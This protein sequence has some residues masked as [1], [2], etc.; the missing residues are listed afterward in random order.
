[1]LTRQKILLQILRSNDGQ[2]SKMELAKLSF[3]LSKEG[4]SEQLKTF[5]E[6]V[7]YFYGPYSFTLTHELNHLLQAGFIEF[8]DETA[9]KLTTYGAQHAPRDFDARLNR[10]LELLEQKYS[11]LSQN[12]LVDLVYEKF[13]WYT[14]KSKLANKRKSSISLAPCANYTIGYQSFQV[15]GLLNKLLESGIARVVDTRN[16]PISRKY[17]YHKSTLAKLCKNI[18]I[19][20]EHRPELG[21]PSSWRQELESESNYAKLF[22]RYENEILEIEEKSVCEIA[23]AMKA[24]PTALLCQEAEPTHCHRMRLAKKLESLN[25]LPIIELGV[26]CAASSH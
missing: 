8:P 25:R 19:T 23:D 6:F 20:Y 15:D 5:Y 1:M 24:L 9:I 4:R 16:N 7:P 10:D 14:V 22:I 13:P 17:G 18:G 26:K 2:C 3:L 12:K 21:I 11:D